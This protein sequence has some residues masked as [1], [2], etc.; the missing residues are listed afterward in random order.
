MDLENCAAFEYFLTDVTF[1]LQFGAVPEIKIKSAVAVEL[2]HLEIEVS[3]L[4]LKS[5]L[6]WSA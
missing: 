5:T 6:N 1:E 3:L 2:S 4:S